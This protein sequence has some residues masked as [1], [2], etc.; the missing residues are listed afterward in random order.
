MRP[1]ERIDDDFVACSCKELRPSGKYVLPVARIVCV[2]PD[3]SAKFIKLAT[4]QAQASR[5]SNLSFFVADAQTENLCGPH[6]VLFARFGTMFFNG[7]GGRSAAR[8]LF[9]PSASRRRHDALEFV[10]R[11]RAKQMTFVS[12]QG[13]SRGRAEVHLRHTGRAFRS[14]CQVWRTFDGDPSAIT[15][16]VWTL[17]YKGGCS[18]TVGTGQCTTTSVRGYVSWNQHRPPCSKWLVCLPATRL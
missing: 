17:G 18:D 16:A 15:R 9:E 5:L 14:L 10:V 7:R 12:G 2:G 11:N 13:R 4:G 3:S 6:D 1:A 8:D